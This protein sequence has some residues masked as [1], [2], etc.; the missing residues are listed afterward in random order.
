MMPSKTT[1]IL[2][3]ALV[4][5]VV[6]AIMSFIASQGGLMTATLGGCGACLAAFAGPVVAVWHYVTTNRL[7]IPAGTGAGL[8]ALT[9]V[10]GAG[11]AF[12]LGYILRALNVLPTTDELL[13]RQRELM[14]NAGLD[15]AQVDAQL[16]AGSAMSGPVAEV[17]IGVLAGLVV[18]AIGGAIAAAVVKRGA[19]YDP[20]DV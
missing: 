17:V 2:I 3:G 6:G 9:G 7:T 19:A 5:A 1:S 13:A 14:I 16:A 18:G 15:P 11:V 12:V 10:V 4:Y 8:G 20:D